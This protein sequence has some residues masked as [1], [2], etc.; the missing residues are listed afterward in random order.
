MP[1]NNVFHIRYRTE[2]LLDSEGYW[3][4]RTVPYVFD[5]QRITYV[6][7]DTP[8]EHA[9]PTI[10]M[11][12]E[13]I[14][15]IEANCGC[16]TCKMRRAESH[17]LRNAVVHHYGYKPRGG[18]RLQSTANDPDDYYLGV[19]LETDNFYRD[20]RG[21]MQ[22]SSVSNGY[23]ADMRRPKRL[24]QASRDGSV[25]GPEFA[26]HPA[27]LRYWHSKKA[28]L[29]LMMKM[30]LHAG[31]RSH[32]NDKAGMHV[33]VSRSAFTDSQHFYRFL[34]LIHGNAAFMLKMSQR[35]RASMSN[36][37]R[38][39]EDDNR[40]LLASENIFATGR[41][42]SN[43]FS[44]GRYTAVNMCAGEPRVEFRLPRGTLRLDRFYKN[45]EWVHS[46]VEFSRNEGIDMMTADH[47]TAYVMNNRD[48][49]GN[50]AAFMTERRAKLEAAAG[51]PL[52]MATDDDE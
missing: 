2:Y 14:S 39:G 42:V 25:S 44:G 11:T 19:E 7:G 37:A 5:G 45:I 33:S 9:A 3:R 46:M 49:Y 34:R 20:G 8:V 50:L 1:N 36:W 17:K 22:R 4:E 26:S 41:W 51:I 27:T 24:W 18:W 16:E 29:G 10:P 38:L 21:V 6:P 52:A 15:D 40:C 31:F 13:V 23:A 48:L 43:Y 47:Y 12:E 30:L 32:D 28:D 35:T